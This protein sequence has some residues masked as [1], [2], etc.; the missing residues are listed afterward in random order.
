MI[1]TIAREFL[2]LLFIL[3]IA[4]PISFLF[5]TA[6]DIVAEGR[7]FTEGERYFII[8]LYLIIYIINVIGLYLT[9]IMIAAIKKVAQ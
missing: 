5:V 2:W 3:I 6:L 1:K 8:E 4:V 7:Y 9:R